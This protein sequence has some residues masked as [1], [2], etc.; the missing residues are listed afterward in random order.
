QVRAGDGR[1]LR[2]VVDGMESRNAEYDSGRGEIVFGYFTAVD[3]PPGALNLSGGKV[4]TALSHDIITHE[5]T[6]ALLDGLRPHFMIA[7]SPD[8]LAFHEALADLIALFRKFSFET[9]VR[10]A[11]AATRGRLDADTALS[12][13]ARQFGQTT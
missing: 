1:R 12:A 3:R 2:L 9:G 5:V 11:L 8:A 13:I 4:H 10:N 6:H 7:T